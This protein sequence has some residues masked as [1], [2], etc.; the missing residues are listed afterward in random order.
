SKSTWFVRDDGSDRVGDVGNLSDG[1]L[2]IDRVVNGQALPEEQDRYVVL[3]SQGIDSEAEARVTPAL[4][5]VIPE[6]IE[7]RRVEAAPAQSDCPDNA[8]CASARWADDHT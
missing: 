8:I 3:T 6:T 4:L 1:V 5:Q 7:G 2:D